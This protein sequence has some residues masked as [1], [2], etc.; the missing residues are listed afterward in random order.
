MEK[1]ISKFKKIH[2]VIIFLLVAGFTASFVFFNTSSNNVQAKTTLTK[3]IYNDYIFEEPQSFD[4]DNSTSIFSADNESGLG[5]YCLRDD[6]IIYT[7]DQSQNGLCWAYAGSTVLATTLMKATGQYYDFSEAWISLANVEKTT[8][9]EGGNKYIF[10][11]GANFDTFNKIAK[12]YGVVLESDFH[13]EDSFL[14]SN[15]NYSSYF[16][17]YSQ[18]ANKEIMN[19]FEVK[20]YSLYSD[21]SEIKQHIKNNGALSI[22]SYWNG[23]SDQNGLKKIDNS[24]MVYKIPNNKK[25]NDNSGHAITI[26]GWDDNVSITKDNNTFTGAWICLNSWGD[27]V[28]FDGVCYVFYDDSD[29]YNIKGFKYNKTSNNLIFDVEKTSGYTYS[30]KLS[31]KYNSKNNA[32]GTENTTLQQ[33]VFF[34]DNVSL[35]Y[36]YKI[37]VNKGSYASG[38]KITGI[39]VYFGQENVSNKFDISYG[40]SY[41]GNY[42]INKKTN[43]EIKVGTYKVLVEYEYNNEKYEHLQVFYVMNGTECAD[44]H[45]TDDKAMNNG[46]YLAFLTYN[47]SDL[48]FTISTTQSSGAVN[49]QII[50]TTYTIFKSKAY[51]SSAKYSIS[52]DENQ[53]SVLVT[54]TENSISLTISIIVVYVES[55]SAATFYYNLNGGTYS[56]NKHLVKNNKA[57]LGEPTKPGFVFTGWYYDSKLEN[58]LEN[59]VFDCSKLI[60]TSGDRYA[61]SYYKKYL[62]NISIAFVY[63]EWEVA[64][65]NE[66][67]VAISLNNNSSVFYYG[68]EFSFKIDVNGPLA[69]LL[70]IDKV[71]WYLGEDD[72]LGTSNGSSFSCTIAN[73]GEYENGQKFN[74]KAEIEAS[75]NGVSLSTVTKEFLFVG[76]N[77]ISAGDITSSSENNGCVFTWDAK[78][79]TSFQVEV[80]NEG[81]N[82]LCTQQINDG[83]SFDLVECLKTL[84]DSSDSYQLSS[85]KYSIKIQGFIQKDGTQYA[86]DV[87]ASDEVEI[88]VYTVAFETIIGTIK[89]SEYL[90]K[91]VKVLSGETIENC[92]VSIPNGY[93]FLG[94][95]KDESFNEIW[96]FETDNV[97][98]NIT[99][100]AKWELNFTV[101]TSS[102]ITKTYDASLS[103]L[104][105]YTNNLP[106]DANNISY[107]WYKGTDKINNGT[108]KS[109]EV[110][111]VSDSGEYY[112]V[113]CVTDKNDIFKEVKSE[114]FSVN[115]SKAELIIN[116]DGITSSYVY[117]PE[118]ITI[119]SGAVVKNENGTNTS[120]KNEISSLTY[121]FDDGTNKIT[122]VGTYTLT[123]KAATNENFNVQSATKEII[124]TKATSTIK[125]EIP[126]QFFKYV[127]EEVAPSYKLEN[128][129][130]NVFCYVMENG[131]KTN[132]TIL[133]V[134][135]YDVKIIAEESNN[136]KEVE[137]D[138][139]VTINPANIYVRVNNIIGVW[140]AKQKDLSYSIIK[141]ELFNDDELNIS[142]KT[143]V[144]TDKI[145][146][147]AI[148]FEYDNPNYKVA[149]FNGKYYVSGWPYYIGAVVLLIVGYF[150]IK[151]LRKRR[152]QYDFETN[153][154]SLV[155]PIDTKNKH[156]IKLEVPVKKGYRFVGWF[157]D[158]EL[159][160]P[161]SKRFV[162][163][164]GKIYYAKWE[165]DD[166]TIIMSDELKNAEK[167]V[168][169]IQNIVNKKE[170]AVEEENNIKQ[171]EEPSVLKEKTNEEKLQDFIDTVANDNNFNVDELE[172]F[173]NRIVDKK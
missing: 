42:S 34:E 170:Q 56:Q 61:E 139:H 140:F 101:Y 117:K 96:D 17:Y 40:T 125:I 54:F 38:A 10:G 152:Y 166:G 65:L 7:Q 80:Y 16:N 114:K 41:S 164:K 23:E 144:K 59:N 4:E 151:A 72:L 103:N 135:E 165:K 18:F 88:S 55:E 155:S 50:P 69:D 137:K 22:S 159:T 12:E 133:N 167:I 142:L 121:S 105:I 146:S 48:T 37:Y 84:S 21:R 132:K 89:D 106:E 58:K 127:G 112:C 126:Y 67:N 149:V 116:T 136:Y 98:E 129:E 100:Y 73:N 1:K 63:A 66:D 45:I 47:Y 157:K 8:K 2:Y 93:N 113:V 9:E 3:P 51:L 154:G 62:E 33:N 11:S 115:I 138:V 122:N 60:V 150:V 118:G 57:T 82:K 162:K 99:L 25:A 31:G 46:Y 120:L 160:K 119:S 168:D 109:F 29:V 172:D 123:V 134:G 108:D 110:K 44:I 35:K 68:N 131:V 85:G 43:A 13:Y 90:E 78:D 86:S 92:E 156:E 5:Y 173:I 74:F 141:G 19:A 83:E 24:E 91:K 148:D 102:N 39:N 30:T 27:T 20:S 26:I 158:P 52:S 111:N 79:Y 36:N 147:Y 28:G 64:T 143:D 49:L 171:V 81:N 95:Y 6:Y 161:I 124:I 94:W 145:G 14:I 32:T 107:Q 163:S 97:T 53:T 70:T 77:G 87:V 130:Q 104:T 75:V 15:S 76:L 153:G 169:D 71:S 128:N